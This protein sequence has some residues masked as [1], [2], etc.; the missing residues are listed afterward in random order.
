MHAQVS[1][2]SS[3]QLTGRCGHCVLGHGPL[4][5]LFLM[6]EEGVFV[7]P[8]FDLTIIMFVMHIHSSPRTRHQSIMFSWGALPSLLTVVLAGSALWVIL[9]GLDAVLGLN[10]GQVPAR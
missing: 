4:V 1:L 7:L 6:G 8:A 9:R 10:Q 3:E 2:A 5:L